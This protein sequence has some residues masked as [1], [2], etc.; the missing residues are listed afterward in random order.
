MDDDSIWSDDREKGLL[1]MRFAGGHYWPVFIDD[2]SKF[3]HHIQSIASDVAAKKEVQMDI[4]F[5]DFS[6]EEMSDIDKD[7]EGIFDQADRDDVAEAN[8]VVVNVSC[9]LA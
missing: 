6:E 1:V 2:W 7:N 9:A 5:I 8:V 4:I 3:R